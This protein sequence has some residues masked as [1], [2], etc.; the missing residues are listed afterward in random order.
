MDEDKTV[1]AVFS[2]I[3]NT[4]RVTVIKTG[5]SGELCLVSSVDSDDRPDGEISC[6]TGCSTDIDQGTRLS[7]RIDPLQG[8][9]CTVADNRHTA[10]ATYTFEINSDTEIAVHGATMPWNIFLPAMLTSERRPPSP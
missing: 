10:T 5:N 7:L 9:T 4:Y 6:G 1:A 2:A 3:I 8:A